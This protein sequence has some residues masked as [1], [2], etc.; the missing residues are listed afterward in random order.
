MKIHLIF[1][2][3]TKEERFNKSIAKAAGI[4]PP[5]GILYVAAALKKNGYDVSVSEGSMEDYE[6]IMK[7]LGEIKPEIVG[8]S[9]MTF[10]WNRTKTM[11]T[12]I[13]KLLPNSF[14]VI[15]GP[16]P[17]VFKET[18]FA[19]CSGLDA[20][21]VGEG[22]ETM[23]ELMKNFD[24]RRFDNINGLIYRKND[25]VKKNAQRIP[26]PDL[27]Q[28]PFPARELIDIKKY[29]PS[30]EEYK[31]LPMTNIMGSRGCPFNCI[32]CSK[33]CGNIVRLR[34]PENI[35]AEIEELVD[36]YGMK[37]IAFYDDT[38]TVNKNFV[39]K[40]TKLLKEK[41]INIIWSVNAR[42]NTVDEKMLHEMADAGCW[43]IFF[44]IES[45]LQKN[46][47]VLKKGTTVEQIF[48]A[49]KWAKSAGIVVE[50][51]FIF[52]IPGESY[53]DALETINLIVK[54]N[55]DYAK[56]FIL[57][58]LPGTELYN[59]VEKYGVMLSNN[60][61]DMTTHKVIFRPFTMTKEELESL[62]PIAYKKF[63]L[64]WNYFLH[65][66]SKI[67]SLEDVKRNYNGV[68][69]LFS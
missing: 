5:L 43:K 12:D 40:F 58:P 23:L 26:I 21:V 11:I 32:Y 18:C 2:P 59:N 61:D 62:V 44:G 22:E 34:S 41:K 3:H 57:T 29:V 10:L 56:F 9:V 69:V 63:Y 16:H 66:I 15:G 31:V 51:S 55:P 39:T 6:T 13:K 68:K 53:K 47:D 14:V 20:A 42:V 52:G 60:L 65:T 17:T 27:D 54:L 48:N 64:R 8:I 30:M 45:M 67:R 33:I 50:T 4:L 46:L 38:F 35:I 28:V 37:G 36:K 1:P 19:E 7:K 49:V 24:A 25:V